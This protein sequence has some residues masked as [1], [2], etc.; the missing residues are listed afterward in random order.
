MDQH[1]R[2]TLSDRKCRGSYERVAAALKLIN[3]PATE[4]ARFFEQVALTAMVRN[5]DGHLKNF[6]V[7]YSGPDDVRLA[8]M[9]DVVTTSIYK[10]QRFDGGPELE[11]HTMALKLFAGAKGSK[12]YPS[13]KDLLDFGRRVCGVSDPAA[14]IQRIAQGM[15][16]A[17][18]KCRTDRRIA[19]PLHA[20]MSAA[21][22]AGLLLARELVRGG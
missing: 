18:A 2:D 6:G 4:L 21:W 10:Y 9:F 11:D 12:T 8:P 7:L 13:A 20:Q 14:V 3:L 1:V 16:Q 5:G 22:Q 15:V 19:A 17:L